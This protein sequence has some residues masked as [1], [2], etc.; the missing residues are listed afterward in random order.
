MK[1]LNVLGE[2]D[3]IIERGALKSVGQTVSTVMGTGK[4]ACVVSDDNVAPIYAEFVLGS[5]RSK[6]IEASLFVFPHGEGSKNI[7]T[8]TEMLSFFAE[9]TLTR[10]DFII[11]LGGGIVGDLAGFAAAIYLRGISFVQIP[12]S[13]LAQIDSSVGGKTGCDLKN[14]KNLVGAFKHPS[15]V[16]ID[17][18]VLETLPDEFM[19]DGMGEMIKYGA[20]KSESLFFRLEGSEP[21]EN[22]DQNIYECVKIKADIVEKDFTEQ[23]ERA[24]LNFGHTVGHAIEKAEN[25]GGISHGAAVA[26]GMC[27]ITRAAE[28]IKLCTE[29]T[30]KRLEALCEKYGLPT[31]YNASVNLIADAAKNDKKRSQNT[32]KLILLRKIGNSFICP[33]GVNEL[34]KIFE[35]CMNSKESK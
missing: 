7:G 15:L 22:I 29:G 12:T 14:G 5:L 33:V 13:L 28:K 16:L 30:A 8:V 17:P 34:E 11:A 23:G 25:F 2:Y 18:D 35:N 4:R 31:E 26:A 1:K 19:R 21:F 20:I 24:L 9:S 10:S 6:G 27:I 32:M 3:I